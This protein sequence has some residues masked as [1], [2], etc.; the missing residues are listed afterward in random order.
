MIVLLKFSVLHERVKSYFE[1]LSQEY[2]CQIVIS[3][4]LN[5][6]IFSNNP[7]LMEDI[8]AQDFVHSVKVLN[9]RFVLA[10]KLAKLAPTKI[11][12]NDEDIFAQKCVISGPCSIE[13]YEQ[14]EKIVSNLT[15][16]G[17]KNIRGGIFK[18]R[19]SFHEF[20]GLGL[21]GIEIVKKLKQKYDFNFVCEVM[22][23]AQ[24][25]PLSEVA[26]ILQVGARN[27]QNYDLLKALGKTKKPVILKRASGGLIQEW[28]SAADYILAGGN[29]NVILCERGIRTFETSY[30]NT[31][32]LNAILYA[33]MHSHLPVISDPSHGSGLDWMVPSLAHASFAV[34]CDA[35][36]I[37]SHFDP[38]NALSDASQTISLEML[39]DFIKQLD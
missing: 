8:K 27:M 15:A 38:A 31:L 9:T 17:I 2:S 20:Q 25:E 21:E 3:D 23:I 10:H 7:K 19:T 30:R 37:E 36:M 18:P 12:I 28:L 22:Q 34:G 39:K 33:K 26:D 6:C 11:V 14:F 29:P 4:V 1:H 16:M 32:D 13:S 35:V 5:V 24:I